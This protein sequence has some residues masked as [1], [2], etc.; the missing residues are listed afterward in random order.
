M[1]SA[2]ALAAPLD[3]V[4]AVPEGV[5]TPVPVEL[6][7]VLVLVLVLALVLVLVPMLVLTEADSASKNAFNCSGC[8]RSM[9]VPL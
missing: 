6:M 8:T 4:G 7:L 3:E 9:M 1:G 2:S 5:T